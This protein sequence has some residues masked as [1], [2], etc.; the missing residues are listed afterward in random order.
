MAQRPEGTLQVRGFDSNWRGQLRVLQ[1]NQCGHASI[2]H[3]TLRPQMSQC[4]SQDVIGQSRFD[5]FDQDVEATRARWG[6]SGA[7]NISSVAT[8]FAFWSLW[9]YERCYLPLR[10]RGHRVTGDNPPQ[11]HEDSKVLACMNV[12]TTCPMRAPGS[13]WWHETKRLL[14]HARNPSSHSR[15]SWTDLAGNPLL[16]DNLHYWSNCRPS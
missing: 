8:I 16:R 13:F 12:G 2:F 6:K 4:L 5:C 15:E 1:V 7:D 11:G 3:S 10:C 9:V 14:K